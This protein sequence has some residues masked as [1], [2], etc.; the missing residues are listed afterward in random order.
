MRRELAT[1]VVLMLMAHQL[2]HCPPA[3]CISAFQCLCIENHDTVAS[4]KC[5]F[6]RMHGQIQVRQQSS[7]FASAGA[8]PHAHKQTTPKAV[9]MPENPV[10]ILEVNPFFW[11][12]LTAEQNLLYSHG[13]RSS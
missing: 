4:K 3:G 6:C 2:Q 9:S 13:E 12:Y 8:H 10:G 1:P 5:G 7:T 11:S